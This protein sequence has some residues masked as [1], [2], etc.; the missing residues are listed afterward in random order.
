MAKVREK[1]FKEVS[2]FAN[3]ST[4][5]NFF[6]TSQFLTEFKKVADFKQFR[7]E[8]KKEKIG[9]KIHIKTK[10]NETEVVDFLVGKSV[11]DNQPAACGS[12]TT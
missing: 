3:S 8:C 6:A 12:F 4:K 5:E 2:T 9:R 10:T 7:F 11:L 1:G